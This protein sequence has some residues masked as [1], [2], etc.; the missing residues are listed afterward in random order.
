[1]NFPNPY[2]PTIGK[3]VFLPKAISIEERLI[4]TNETVKKRNIGAFKRP[5]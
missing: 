3:K 1:M 2:P 5:L 4:P